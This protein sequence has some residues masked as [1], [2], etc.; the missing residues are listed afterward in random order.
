MTRSLH[1]GNLM[2]HLSTERHR[3]REPNRGQSLVE[4]ALVVPILLFLTVIALDFGRVYL[5]WI[6]LQS[7]TRIAANT[8]ANNPTA[9]S[10]AGLPN[11]LATYQA[12]VRNDASA[13]NC[14]L[15]LVGGKPTAPAPVFSGTN[16]GDTVTVSMSCTFG[17]IT[18]GVS[19]VLGGSI[20]VSSSSTFPVKAG[21]TDPGGGGP[22]LPAP[23]AA[24]SANGTLAPNAISG[25]APFTVVFRDTSGG[26]PS[27][28]LWTFPDDGTTSTAQ[29]PLGHTFTT[30]GTYVVT[31]TATNTTGS[32]TTSM[33]V[34]V[35]SPT[36]TDFTF[37]QSAPN[38]PS[39]VTFTNASTPGATA[40]DWSFGTGEGTGSGETATHT[41]TTAGTYTVTLTVTYPTETLTVSKTVTVG[42]GL[43]VV[44]SLNGVHRNN[45][46]GVWTGAGFTGTVSDGPG[47]PNG[48]YVITSQSLTAS[49]SV[50]CNSSVQVNRP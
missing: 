35:T 25:T 7:M 37:T 18:P 40:W 31:M 41:Y 27:S 46:Q 28:W 17:V 21:M 10:G 45:A 3:R 39:L 43:C 8:A 20:T 48:N 23:S 9:W 5:G 22:G 6:N 49:S 44:P 50:P 47:A 16:I 33:G 24:F 26:S 30:P 42:S 1:P 29:D 32:S 19:N 12:Q 13:T 38:V 11:V 36:S 34:T 14:Q 15:P 2:R 4:F